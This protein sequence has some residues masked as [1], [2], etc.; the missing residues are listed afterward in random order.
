MY[1]ISRFEFRTFSDT[2]QQKKSNIIAQL[3]RNLRRGRCVSMTVDYARSISPVCC[4]VRRYL[5]CLRNSSLFLFNSTKSKVCFFGRPQHVLVA[6]DMRHWTISLSRGLILFSNFAFY[7][8]ES[9]N[10]KN[11][12]THTH[13]HTH[14]HMKRNVLIHKKKHIVDIGWK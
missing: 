13:T 10:K 5:P 9:S 2:L 3:T 12:H 14:T 11:P 8:K 7:S 6:F 4:Q 1:Q